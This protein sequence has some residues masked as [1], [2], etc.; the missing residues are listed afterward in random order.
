MIDDNKK[1]VK[2][3]YIYYSVCFQENNVRVLFYN[4]NKVN[5]ISFDFIEKLGFKI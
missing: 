4:G 1:V 5:A 3:P 2:M